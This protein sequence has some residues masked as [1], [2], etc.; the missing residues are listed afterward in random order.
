VELVDRPSDAYNGLFRIT[1][2]HTLA[3]EFERFAYPVVRSVKLRGD[4]LLFID[5]NANQ[6]VYWR[7]Q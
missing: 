2:G 6:E 5:Q 4:Q 3:C 1:N 7:S